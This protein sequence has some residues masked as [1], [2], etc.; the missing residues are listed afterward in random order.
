MDVGTCCFALLDNLAHHPPFIPC[1]IRLAKE[2]SASSW[3]NRKTHN[4]PFT[5]FLSCKKSSL[6]CI[7]SF[8]NHTLLPVSRLASWYGN[9]ISFFLIKFLKKFSMLSHKKMFLWGWSGKFHFMDVIKGRWVREAS[10]KWVRELK[11]AQPDL[12]GQSDITTVKKSALTHTNGLC[13]LYTFKMILYA[14]YL[15]STLEVKKMGILVEKLN[16][17]N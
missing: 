17:T 15:Y 3:R 1:E 2:G 16:R 12:F 14:V 9:V 6:F 5:F 4:P 13:T 11:P 7:F 10:R 8:L